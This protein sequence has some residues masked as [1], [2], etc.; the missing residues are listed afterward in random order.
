[1]ANKSRPLIDD[2]S[3][4]VGIGTTTTPTS[5]LQV[6][7]NI[8]PDLPSTYSLGSSTQGWASAY[9]TSIYGSVVSAYVS[10]NATQSIYATSSLSASLSSTSSY[11]YSLSGSGAWRM[12]V[13]SSGDLVFQYF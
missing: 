1:M 10:A 8:V 12:Y 6:G 11:F 3:G 4:N 9:I 2:S 13:S 5:K 7:G